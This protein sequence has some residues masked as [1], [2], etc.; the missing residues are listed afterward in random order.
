MTSHYRKHRL[1]ASFLSSWK[2]LPSF[3]Y[4]TKS[5]PFINF[6]PATFLNS[7]TLSLPAGLYRFTPEYHL[8]ISQTPLLTLRQLINRSVEAKKSEEESELYR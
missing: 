3:L 1:H 8:P 7:R 6:N 5:Y 2:S 4:R